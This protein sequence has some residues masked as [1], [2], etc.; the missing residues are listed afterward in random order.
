MDF[1]K[2]RIIA[3]ANE[4]K[5]WEFSELGPVAFDGP[6]TQHEERAANCARCKV[7]AVEEGF[8]EACEK[9]IAEELGA[10]DAGEW[11]I[12]D[13]EMDLA[14]TAR[15]LEEAGDKVDPEWS[16]DIAAMARLLLHERQRVKFE[17]DWKQV[18]EMKAKSKK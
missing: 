11:E 1:E 5:A 8:R 17:R 10:A 14:F 9:Q 4:R 6:C 13:V 3:R 18:Q 7:R 16:V 15:L 2:A 12:E